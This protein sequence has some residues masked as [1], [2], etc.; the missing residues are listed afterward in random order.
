[1]P[2][3]LNRHRNVPPLHLVA[4][5]RRG[6]RRLHRP[7]RLLGHPG[8]ARHPLPCG[9]TLMLLLCVRISDF[10]RLSLSNH[11]LLDQAPISS[12]LPSQSYSHSFSPWL[13]TNCILC[14]RRGATVPAA[15]RSTRALRV[16][17]PRQPLPPAPPPVP[18]LPRR[19]RRCRHHLRLLHLL[20]LYR[21]HRSSHHPR[22]R[23]PAPP[24]P[25]LRRVLP[26]SPPA[27]LSLVTSAAR[28]RRPPSAQRYAS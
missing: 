12:S 19:R 8:R 5:G 2:Q 20:R 10:S 25:R 26:T 18:R 11:G 6:P 13:S 7:T 28:A 3:P 22:P 21:C 23:P 14:R 17:R 16:R 27:P 4:G 1:M 15:V 9:E 24:L